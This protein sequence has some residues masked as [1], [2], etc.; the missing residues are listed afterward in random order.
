MSVAV[1]QTRV[2]EPSR[3]GVAEQR[4]DS[5]CAKNSNSE[6]CSLLRQTDEDGSLFVTSTIAVMVDA[7]GAA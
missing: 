7:V 3:I 6:F 5:V 1:S 4:G 2:T